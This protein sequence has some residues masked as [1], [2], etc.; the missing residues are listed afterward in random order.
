VPGGAGYCRLPD[1]RS[2]FVDG[3][4]PGDTVRVRGSTDK[5][6][7]VEITRFELTTPSPERVTPACPIAETCGGCDWMALPYPAQLRHKAGLVVEALERTARLRLPEAPAV[8]SAGDALAYRL[9]VRLH[10]EADGRVGFFGRRTQVLV[11][12]PECLVV[13]PE[14]R[15]PMAAL[16]ALDVPRRRTLGRGFSSVDLRAVPG[17]GGVELELEPREGSA[18]SAGA[19]AELVSALSVHARVGVGAGRFGLRRYD[20]PRGGFLRVPSGGFTQVNWAV[21]AELVARVVAGAERR[22]ARRFVDLYA[23]VGNFTVPLGL[24][25]LGGVAVELERSAVAALREALREQGLD[26]IEAVAGDVVATLRRLA[27]TYAGADLVLLDPPRAGAKGA[28]EPLIALGAKAIAYVAC[29]PVTLARDLRG[30]VAAG[31][32]V[33]EVVC[34]D[35]FPQ[36]H[37]VETLVWLARS[38]PDASG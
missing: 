9:R 28:V 17:G 8:V 11:D 12:V 6:S 29:D 27:P 20:L 34:F 35:M 14:L 18:P 16:R 37:H 33:E 36:T 24:A 21:N 32:A 22:G 15:A 38:K 19:V 31:Y 4:L 2:A 26:G 13:A 3:A 30:L 7:Y 25:G 1:G 5:K 10:V 23:G